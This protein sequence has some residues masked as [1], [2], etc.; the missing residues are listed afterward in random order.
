MSNVN[1][2]NEVIDFLRKEEN[3]NLFGEGRRITFSWFNA[4]RHGCCVQMRQF[5]RDFGVVCDI[6]SRT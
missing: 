5:F 1:N 3:R 4:S 6:P 2:P